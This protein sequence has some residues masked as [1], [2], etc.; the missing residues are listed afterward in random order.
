MCRFA[1][2]VRPLD[3][4]NFFFFRTFTLA[5]DTDLLRN[6]RARFRLLR[7]RHSAAGVV[8]PTLWSWRGAADIVQ[9]A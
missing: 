6:V 7:N 3:A 4:F 5:G 8:S 1:T 9:P 2:V